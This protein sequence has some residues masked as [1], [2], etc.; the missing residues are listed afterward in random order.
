[1]LWSIL[2]FSQTRPHSRGHLGKYTI[3]GWEGLGNMAIFAT[4]VS[5]ARASI[6]WAC[7]IHLSHYTG[8]LMVSFCL[9]MLSLFPIDI[10]AYLLRWIHDW[11]VYLGCPVMTSSLYRVFGFLLVLIS[12]SFPLSTRKGYHPCFCCL[13]GVSL[14]RLPCGCRSWGRPGSTFGLVF[15]SSQVELYMLS[16]SMLRSKRVSGIQILSH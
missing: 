8:Q 2:I 4:H 1:M 11:L 5:I 13:P 15:R 16:I 9:L 6:C 7:C 14:F 12:C 3:H 10:Q